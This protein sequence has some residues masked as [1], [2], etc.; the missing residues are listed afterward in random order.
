MKDIT[1]NAA[2]S[3]YLADCDKHKHLARSTL[4]VYKITL[5]DFARHDPALNGGMVPL[6]DIPRDIWTGYMDGREHMSNK[7]WNAILSRLSAFIKWSCSEGYLQTSD[8]HLGGLRLRPNTTTRPKT[9]LRAD[10]LAAVL[11][12]AQE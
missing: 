7:G 11:D 1:Y 4:R 12:A 2:V 9:F 5:L 6:R 10:Q 3:M 8:K